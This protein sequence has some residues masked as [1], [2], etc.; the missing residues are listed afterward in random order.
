MP[1]AAITQDLHFQHAPNPAHPVAVHIPA[2]F[3]QTRPFLL[4]V[5]MHGLT[6]TVPFEA[7]I[8][9][10][11]GQM[12]AATTNTILVAPRFDG[13]AEGAFAATMGFSA[14]VAELA[15]KLP[16]LL[17]GLSPA[18]AQAVGT[19]AAEK[20]RIVLV[21]F[22]GSW[23][24][25]AAILDGLRQLPAGAT[26]PKRLVAIELLDSVYGDIPRSRRAVIAWMTARGGDTVLIS[27][28]NPTTGLH[29]KAGNTKLLAALRPHDPVHD[30]STWPTLANPL[31]AGSIAFFAVSTDHLDIPADGPP[32]HPIASLLN[33]LADRTA[34][35]TS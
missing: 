28:F 4:C 27:L 7:H 19:A 34:I 32:A 30:P 24:P 35:P 5:F 13:N 20:A 26:L 22:S 12:A 31:S 1:A 9:A 16:P 3:D 25:C 23:R 2:A 8:Q 11:I 33:R 10:A 18:D 14:F 29:A 17:I 15:Q 21:A 6:T